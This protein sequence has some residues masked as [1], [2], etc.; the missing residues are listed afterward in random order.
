NTVV[1]AD[2]DATHH[3]HAVDQVCPTADADLWAHDAERA[4]P[5][6]IVQLGPRID[7]R[8]WFDV[9]G[10]YAVLRKPSSIRPSLSRTF[11]NSA[12]SRWPLLCAIKWPTRSQPASAR[13]PTRSRAL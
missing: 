10:H 7:D 2:R 1:L 12:L 3:R 4:N 5:D 11:T 8:A 13:S 9:D 6:L